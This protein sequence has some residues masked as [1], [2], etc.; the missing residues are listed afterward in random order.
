MWL[1]NNSGQYARIYETTNLLPVTTWPSPGIT[2]NRASNAQT[3]PAY[4]DVQAVMYSTNFVYIKSTDLASHRMGPWYKEYAKINVNG[5]WPK[6]QANTTK[7]PRFPQ[8]AASPIQVAQGPIGVLLNGVTIANFGD[9]ATYNTATGQDVGVTGGGVPGNQ[10]Q[11]WIRIATGAEGPILD[12]GFGHPAPDGGYHFHANPRSLR[13]Q[14]GDNLYYNPT[15]DTYAEHTTNLHHSPLLGWAYDGYPIYG[16]YGYSAATNAASPVRRMVSGYVVRDGSYGTANLAV[17]G[18]HS[19]PAW[20]ALFH[21]FTATLGTNDYQL[22]ATNYGPNIS[23]NFPI[24]WYAEDFDFLGDRIESGTGSNY[25]QAV[26][27]DLDKPN[28]RQCVTPEFPGGT[29]A[30]FLPVDTNG[31]PAF[32]Y[33]IGRNWYGT[34]TGGR[35]PN[36]NITQTVTTNFIGG[37]NSELRLA[38]PVVSNNVVTLAW[39]ATEGGTYRI[40][41]SGNLSTWTT[42]ANGVAAVFNRGTFTTPVATNQFF[43]IIRTALDAYDP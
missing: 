38:Q 18:R 27:Y 11:V 9:G 21:T 41:T 37:P 14:L 24:G 12:P 3:N 34:N 20:A 1:T 7:L 26:A 42:N 6:S 29:Y 5:L 8:P 28:G 30:Y 33:V 40:E 39:S 17:T 25:Q 10:A 19:L 4:V 15:N 13:L 43:R 32:P 36:G 22:S 35:I 23:T 16:P 2:L 31:A